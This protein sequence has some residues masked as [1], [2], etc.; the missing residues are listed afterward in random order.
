MELL[1]QADTRL[2]WLLNIAWS[3][4]VADGFMIFAASS[5]LRAVI[6]CSAAFFI[7]FRRGRDGAMIL[8]LALL[9]A[10]AAGGM[11]SGVLDP[12]FERSGHGVVPWERRLLVDRARFSFPILFCTSNAAAFGAIVWIFFGRGPAVEKVFT[13]IVATSACLTAYAMVYVGVCYPGD[14]VAAAAIGVLCAF[15]VYTVFAW[16]LKN[17]VR[18]RCGE[19]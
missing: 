10:A 15:G 3:H 14:V 16:L 19:V 9:A 8:L 17:R 6:V 2:F 4:P 12:L 13:G 7:V 11:I 1:Q 18:A 5:T